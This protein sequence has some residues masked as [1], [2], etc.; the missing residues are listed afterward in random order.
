MTSAS[1]TQRSTKLSYAPMRAPT[2]PRIVLMGAQR[3]C[4]PPKPLGNAGEPGQ[5]GGSFELAAAGEA[6]LAA[7]GPLT[8]ATARAAREQGLQALAR[9]RAS[10]LEIDCSGITRSDSAGL[11]VLLDW[12]GAVKR[13]G[14]TLR[15]T[16]LP[17]GLSALGRAAILQLRERARRTGYG[18]RTFHDALLG[19]GSIPPPL[20]A[21]ELGL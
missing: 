14:G 8:F 1:R 10:G 17:E 3:S 20:A 13:A 12:L 21:A 5:G 9:T 18:M 7:R 16:R 15:Y 19:C 11:A 4:R 6:R 2:E